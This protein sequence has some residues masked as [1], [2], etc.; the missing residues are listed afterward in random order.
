MV[1]EV[2]EKMMLTFVLVCFG[3][4]NVNVHAQTDASIDRV[5]KENQHK[6]P[7]LGAL[8]FP[9]RFCPLLTPSASIPS[10]LL[11]R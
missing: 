8:L 11:S 6:I 2:R 9:F 1:S 3:I 5:I 7:K 10:C 4:V